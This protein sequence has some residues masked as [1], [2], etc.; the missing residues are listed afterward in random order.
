MK[1]LLITACALMVSLAATYGQGQLNF[2]T[3]VGSGATGVNAKIIDQATGLGATSPPF[4]AALVLAGTT[5]PIPGSITT[6]RSCDDY[7]RR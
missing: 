6:F 3:K 5:T 1:K 2:A 4:S 7:F